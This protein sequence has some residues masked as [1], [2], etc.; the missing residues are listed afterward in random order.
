[1]NI[2]TAIDDVAARLLEHEKI[3]Q[4]MQDIMERTEQSLARMKEE[5]EK[6]L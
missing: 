6:L 2:D 3:M 5:L 1:M 4:E